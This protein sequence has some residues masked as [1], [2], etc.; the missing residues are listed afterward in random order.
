MASR[1][2]SAPNRQIPR[3][4]LTVSRADADAVPKSLSWK[5]VVF[6]FSSSGSRTPSSHGPA[7]RRVSLV[8]LA[9]LLMLAFAG[10]AAAATPPVGLGTADSFAILGGSAI[11][12][13]GNSV[14][15][16]DMG[17]HPGTSIT[18]FP[19]GTVN[20]AQHVTDAVAQQAKTDLTTAYQ[21]AA[22][23]SFSATLPPDVGGRT[24]TGGV[25]RT[26]SVASLGLTGRLTL[27][28]Q[29]DPRAVF[30]FQIPSTLVTATDSS[31]RLVNGAQAC[32]VFWLSLI[33]I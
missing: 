11:T 6:M 3:A 32:N 33:H 5:V 21:D 13:T 12:N 9:S 2:P 7:F 19:P 15:N 26:G 30:I 28:A 24:L 18:G 27:D 22:G 1:Y 29:G 16:G 25:Y 10:P 23:R 8:A 17:L 4:R 20:G 31:V 14:I